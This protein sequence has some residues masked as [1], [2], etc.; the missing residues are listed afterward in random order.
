MKK[1]LFPTWDSRTGAGLLF[2]E[3]SVSSELLSPQVGGSPHPPPTFA[4][5][6][7]SPFP[8]AFVQCKFPVCAGEGFL[9]FKSRS[10]EVKASVFFRKQ[11]CISGDAAE[12][13][14]EEAFPSRH[15]KFQIA[16]RSG[17]GGAIL[18]KI[19]TD[20]A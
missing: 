15:K 2:A 5:S 19:V 7:R 13:T 9:N 17:E 16:E 12:H 18:P 6:V 3:I 14:V 20:E 4:E 1:D 8:T 10:M 11:H